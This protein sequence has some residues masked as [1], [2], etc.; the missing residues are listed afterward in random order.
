MKTFVK[1]LPENF[2]EEVMDLE[3]EV[4]TDNI[5]LGSVKK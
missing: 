3:M 5:Q 4:K 1:P 2:A